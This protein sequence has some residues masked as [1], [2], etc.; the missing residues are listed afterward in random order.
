MTSLSVLVLDDDATLAR[1]VETIVRHL[2]HAAISSS[3]PIEMCA[4]YA[5]AA[6]PVDA[7][8]TDL[9]MPGM[10]GVEVCEKFMIACPRV[11]RVV[12]TAAPYDPA[13]RE[14]VTRGIV[15]LVLSKP[16]TIDDIRHALG[17]P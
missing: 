8:I 3:L 15:Q 10:T 11:R 9:M 14:A 1:L 12:L 5:H 2:G 17:A 4:R 13:L 6:S 16:A 7:V